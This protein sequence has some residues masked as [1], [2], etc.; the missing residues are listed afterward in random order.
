MAL[1]HVNKLLQTN[2]LIIDLKKSLELREKF[3]ENEKEVLD[4]YSLTK[5]ELEAIKARDFKKLYDIGVHQYLIAQLA[6]L[7][8]GTADGSNDGG[9]VKILMDQMLQD[10]N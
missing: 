9:S 10:E 1:D 4:M 5:E 7:I 8:Y 3:K 2:E 6:R